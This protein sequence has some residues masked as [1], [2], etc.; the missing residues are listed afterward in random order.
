LRLW[1]FAFRANPGKTICPR[2]L[3]GYYALGWKEINDGFVF[4][5]DFWLPA[6]NSPNAN[7]FCSSRRKP[8]DFQDSLDC[9]PV[10]RKIPEAKSAHD[11]LRFKLQLWA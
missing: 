1:N 7:N 6:C 10:G 4:R 9:G 8:W 3:P 11:E 5:M 2:A